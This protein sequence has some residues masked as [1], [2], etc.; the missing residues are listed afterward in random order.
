LT[1][2]S[3]NDLNAYKQNWNNIDN[4]NF[5]GDKIYN[6][7]EFFINTRKNNNSIMITSIKEVKDMPENRKQRDNAFNNLFS[8]AIARIRQ[9]IESLFNWLIEKT[10]IQRFFLLMDC[11]YMSLVV[12]QQHL[13]FLFSTLNSHN[14]YICISKRIHVPD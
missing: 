2:S 8:T 11:W 4:R 13:Y 7:S 12:L 14:F 5:H 3:E 1:P 10:D 6:D 9:P